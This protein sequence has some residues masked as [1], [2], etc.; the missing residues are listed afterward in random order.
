MTFD[1]KGK[2]I[3]MK[4]PALKDLDDGVTFMDFQF[5]TQAKNPQKKVSKKASQESIETGGGS[6]PS[7][8]HKESD[9]NIKPVAVQMKEMTDNAIRKYHEKHMDPKEILEQVKPFFGVSLRD[10]SPDGKNPESFQPS[11]ELEG[12]LYSDNPMLRGRKMSRLSYNQSKK[13]GLQP[14]YLEK[15]ETTQLKTTLEKDPNN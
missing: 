6:K 9:A 4:Q 10:R 2:S 5:T 8:K 13:I 11:V 14:G 1:F 7:R 3:R 15:L 12:G